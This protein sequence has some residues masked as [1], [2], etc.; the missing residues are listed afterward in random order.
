MPTLTQPILVTHPEPHHAHADVLT[1]AQFLALL[2]E[3]EDYFVGEQHNTNLSITRLRKIFYDQ[4]GWN[5]ELIRAA[6]AVEGRYVVT[7]VSDPATVN[8]P[9]TNPNIANTTIPK[10]H[11][12]P[13]RRYRNN[14]YQPK[15][16]LVTYRPDDR[17]YGNTRVGQ[18]AFIYQSDHQ[19]VLLPDGHYCDLAHVLSGLDALNHPQIVSPLPAFL[20]FLAHLGPHVESNA[21]MATWLGDIGSSAGDFLHCYLNTDQKPL[22]V[23]QEQK[24]INLD[25]PGSD[26][27][28]NIDAYVIAHHYDVGSTNGLRF[29]DILADYYEPDAPG[30]RFRAH[31]FSTFCQVIGLEGWNGETFANEA[32]WLKQYHWQLRN[33]T[34]FQLYSLTEELLSSI[35][36]MLRVYFNGYSSVLKLDILL[37][38]YLDGLKEHIKQEPIH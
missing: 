32:Q 18:V 34:C 11:A 5:S 30:S 13:L 17:V 6:A 31:R 27:L 7:I 28:G 33:E 24:F 2:R 10:A 15:H 26:M 20:S 19:E 9:N 8:V 3:E 4:W 25:A 22:S 12:K 37:Q 38:L 36:L 23:G 16:R 1:F 21:D 35:W 14:S 29:T